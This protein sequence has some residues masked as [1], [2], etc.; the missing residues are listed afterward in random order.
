MTRPDKKKQP[1]GFATD[2]RERMPLPPRE[3]LSPAQREAADALI[4]GPRKGVKGPFIPLLRTPQLMERLSA[5]GAYL[6]FESVLEPRINEFVT[7]IVARE[8]GNQFEWAVHSPLAISAGV[9][10]HVL[11]RLADGARPPEMAT[12]EALAYD[13]AVELLRRNGVCDATYALAR[14]CWGEQGVVELTS[15]I[16]YFATVCWVMNV[17]RTPAPAAD[18]TPLG[19]FPV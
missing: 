1:Q 18:V 5:V 9:T 6:R 10:A 8:T 2:A 7:A 4:A 11:E 16:G 14:D 17:A 3:S 12:D 13:F 15:L 19:A